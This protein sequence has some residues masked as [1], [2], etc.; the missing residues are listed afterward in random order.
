[1]RGEAASHLL[2]SGEEPED[3]LDV[4]DVLAARWPI[5]IDPPAGR[6]RSWTITLEAT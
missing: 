3:P 2:S 1:V 6:N 4:A 5:E